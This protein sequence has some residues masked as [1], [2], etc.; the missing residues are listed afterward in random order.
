[1]SRIKLGMEPNRQDPRQDPNFINRSRD[2]SCC[3]ITFHND[4]CSDAQRGCL[5]VARYPF[6]PEPLQDGTNGDYV[7]LSIR[8][9]YGKLEDFTVGKW[10]LNFGTSLGAT[11][12]K[13]PLVIEITRSDIVQLFTCCSPS[14]DIYGN[15]CR[16]EAS[17]SVLVLHKRFSEK[18]RVQIELK[19]DN[20]QFAPLSLTDVTNIQTFP[21]TYKQAVL[22]K[23]I[24]KN[25]PL[26]GYFCWDNT[27]KASMLGEK[28]KAYS[29]CIRYSSGGGRYCSNSEPPLGCNERPSSGSAILDQNLMCVC[30][31]HNVQRRSTVSLDTNCI[32]MGTSVFQI[33]S[34]LIGKQ[35]F[36]IINILQLVYTHIH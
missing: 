33:A 36:I 9:L 8:R 29:E 30:G 26:E 4:S 5:C 3:N 12:S 20:R 15:I 25:V 21:V 18:L 19:A 13:D 6:A 22:K 11:R 24:F 17:F 31:V 2:Y 23:K 7:V 32:T 10:T 35:L 28:V 16:C 27:G 14:E 34:Q 1:M